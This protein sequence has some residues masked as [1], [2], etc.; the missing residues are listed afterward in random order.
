MMVIF[1]MKKQNKFKLFWWINFLIY[2]SI[3]IYK[4][5][6]KA[7][8]NYYRVPMKYRD[9]NL[10][11]FRSIKRFTQAFDHYSFEVC[12]Y[13]IYGNIL[14]FMP[15]GFLLPFLYSKLKF[16]NVL[17]IGFVMSLGIE[18]CQYITYLGTFDVDDLLLNTIGVVL[19]YVFNKFSIYLVEQNWIFVKK[20][21]IK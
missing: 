19:G 10:T 8:G 4:V 21:E 1:S 14:A 13:N 2:I 17:I 3:L 15:I 7:Y 12:F 20:E 9:Y 18:V 6:I 11:L 16:L 5:F